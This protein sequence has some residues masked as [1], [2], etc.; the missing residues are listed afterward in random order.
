MLESSCTIDVNL[1]IE[2]SCED[3]GSSWAELDDGLWSVDS[4]TILVLIKIGDDWP[5]IIEFQIPN[6]YT[7]VISYGGKD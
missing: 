2:V 6:F 1:T 3:D 4:F 5:E 7:T